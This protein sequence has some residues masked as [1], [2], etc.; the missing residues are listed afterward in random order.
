MLAGLFLLPLLFSTWSSLV[1]V[2][3]VLVEVLA[4]VLADSV[5]T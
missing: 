1:V 4:V 5:Q 2:V 3:Q